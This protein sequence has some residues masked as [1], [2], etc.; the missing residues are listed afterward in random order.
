LAWEEDQW[1]AFQIG[2]VHFRSLKPCARCVLITV[3]PLTGKKD[4][5]PLATLSSFRKKGHK[6]LFGMNTCWD[7]EQTIGEPA[8][9]KVGDETIIK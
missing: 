3:D 7:F 8:I 6:V 4:K 1:S 2:K 9:I 5:E